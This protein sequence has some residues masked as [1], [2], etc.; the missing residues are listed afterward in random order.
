M[1]GALTAHRRHRPQ[2]LPLHP[3]HHPGVPGTIDQVVA[4]FGIELDV[5]ELCKERNVHDRPR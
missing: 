1:A 3:F 2:Q 4:F 5:V